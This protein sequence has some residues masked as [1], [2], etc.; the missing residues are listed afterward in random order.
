MVS[1]MPQV[2]GTR[3]PTTPSNTPS[4]SYRVASGDSMSRI[5]QRHG[6]TVQ[7]LVDA[8]AARYPSLTTNASN[9]QVGWT[10]SIPSG[11]APQTPQ[12]PTPQAPAGWAPRSNNN[13][14]LVGMNESSA[15]EADH[16][17]SRGANVTHV[18]DAKVND[19]ITTRD[20]YGNSQTHDL[21]SKEGSTAFALT[22]GLPAEQTQKIADVIHRSG[23]DSRDEL[24]QLA[25]VWAQA[26]RG[27]QMPSRMVLSGHNVGSGVWGDHNGKL[28]FDTLGQLAEAMPRAARSVEDLHLSAC[29][30]GGEPLM[31]KYRAMFPN[32]N[33]IWAYTG[34]APGSYSGATAH[35]G[36]WESATRGTK[37]S[38]SRELA[39]GT[40]KGENVSVWSKAHG[41]MDGSPQAPLS[42]VRDVV[43]R[44]QATFE[45]FNSG[46]EKVSDPQTGALRSFYNDVQRLLQHPELP[47][48]ERRGLEV[49]R[50]ATIRLLYYSKTVAGNFQNA[51]G[52]Q[53][54]AGFE[55]LGLEVPDFK[56]LS[57][58]DALAAIAT[59]EQK[60][61]GTSPA[62]D[63]ASRLAPLLTDGLRDL[64]ASAIPEAWI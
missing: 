39:A 60:L 33:T 55:S 1:H 52:A 25:Q 47:A 31:D 27:G 58:A 7:Q 48:S 46:A 54:R 37:E 40:R 24:A 18:K 13:V 62:P 43:A 49:Q 26:E 6:V 42:E 5:A 16:L 10:L 44:G 57:R 34:S 14:V 11:R 41:Y 22:L 12:T 59:F 61:A 19:T 36:R 23:A 32:V 30:S 38:L 2:N 53:L 51:H 45:R 64:R 56:S 21:S 35:L 17:R 3:T 20:A 9:I 28:S 50:D 63:A 15:H 8:N 4:D 29:Y